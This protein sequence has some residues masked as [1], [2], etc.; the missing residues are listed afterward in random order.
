VDGKTAVHKVEEMIRHTLK[1][2]GDL[3][4]AVTRAIEARKMEEGKRASH[5]E[6]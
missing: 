5:F 2:I 4:A 1:K 3:K 6:N